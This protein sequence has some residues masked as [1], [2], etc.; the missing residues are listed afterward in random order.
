[1]INGGN[2]Q[3]IQVMVDENLALGLKN[4]A[5]QAGLSISSY[6]RL[7][8][9]SAYKKH[10]SPLEKSLLETDGD[11]TSSGEEF[12]KDIREMISNA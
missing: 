3:K 6:A 5:K 7:L 2:M 10:T 8:L 1:L 4:N 12:L 11:V 9:A